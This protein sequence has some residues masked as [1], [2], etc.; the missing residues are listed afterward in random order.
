MCPMDQQTILNKQ[1]R[2][3]I[4]AIKGIIFVVA[5]TLAGRMNR[6]NAQ[7]AIIPFMP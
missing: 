1:R 4:L 2:R 5:V 6:R 3:R 7:M